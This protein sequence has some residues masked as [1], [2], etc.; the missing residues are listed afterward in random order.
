MIAFY[1]DDMGA[2]M[3]FFAMQKSIHAGACGAVVL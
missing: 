1:W 3:L 2:E